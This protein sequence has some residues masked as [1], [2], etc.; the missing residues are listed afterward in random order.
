MTSGPQPRVSAGTRTGGQWAP[1][2]AA[3]CP[4]VSLSLDDPECG[5][6][7]DGLP[8]GNLVAEMAVG[9][10][11]PAPPGAFPWQ[12][13]GDPVGISADDLPVGDR[14]VASVRQMHD[15]SHSHGHYDDPPLDPNCWKW[16][17]RIGEWGQ[18]NMFGPKLKSAELGWGFAET[19]AG[20]M[21]A[22]QHA[23][24]EHHLGEDL[25]WWAEALR[26]AA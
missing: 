25:G 14:Y 20:A 10:G 26:N 16:E 15:H 4:D 23:I 18:S 21:Q 6:D 1:R 12:G 7:D 13:A 5:T 17:V 8:E 24:D 19:R 3:D 22:A 9:P 11:A 2:P